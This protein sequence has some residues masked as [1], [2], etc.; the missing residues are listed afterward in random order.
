MSLKH[1]LCNSWF[2]RAV[3]VAWIVSA[4]FAYFLLTRID[5]IVHGQLY[6]FG[7]HFSPDWADPYRFYMWSI[8]ICLGLPAALNAIALVFSFTKRIQKVPE[9][10]SGVEQKVKPH[11]VTKEEQ[12]TGENDNSMVISCPNCKKVFP[13]PLVM[14]DFGDGKPMLIN[15]CPYC[16]HSLG[17]HEGEK[18]VGS[19]VYVANA[20]K[21][22]TL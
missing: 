10:K 16:N 3:L 18:S 15:V 22:L 9:N 12:K 8:Y 5:L 19:S 17:T 6:Y 13:K 2:N 4:V 1:V 14:L 7:L 20:N 11:P 21:K